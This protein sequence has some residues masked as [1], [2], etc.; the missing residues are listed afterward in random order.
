MA[1]GGIARLVCGRWT[2]WVV[3]ALWVVVL[4]LAGP[5]AGKLTGVE[6]NDNSAWLPGG[7]ESTAVMN[8]QKQFNPEDI[9]PAVVV[10]ERTAGITPADRAKAAA[11]ARAFA[12][13]PG[14]VGQVLGPVPAKD[15]TA[16]QTIVPIRVDAN[17]WHAITDVVDDVKGISSAGAGGMQ[18][19]LTGPA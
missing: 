8:L 14:V 11:D 10:Y 6:K 2:K 5:L 17:G 15:G 4:A 12:T 9:V 19:F 7:A 1:T 13:V 3:L 18:V 16:I